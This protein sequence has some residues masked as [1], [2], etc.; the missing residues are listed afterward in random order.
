MDLSYVGKI[1]RGEQLP[2]LKTL[3][4]LA[5]ALGV[6][7]GYFFETA[8]PASLSLAKGGDGAGRLWRM[9]PRLRPGDL[10]LLEELVR[11]LVR[12]R[13]ERQRYPDVGR[14]G[15][16]AAE[17]RRRYPESG[18]RNRRRSASRND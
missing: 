10:P 13:Q 8:S 9:I 17:R 2:S 18:S 1:E 3:L 11:V 7:L 16:R 5:T 15:A 14:A 4:R 6:P 12:H